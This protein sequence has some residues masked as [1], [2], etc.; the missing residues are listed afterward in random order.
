MPGGVIR[1][2]WLAPST[3]L[4]PSSAIATLVQPADATASTTSSAGWPVAS[5]ARR[6]AAMSLVMPLAVSVCTANTA[7]I[8]CCGSSRRAWATSA[9]SIGQP[10]RQGVRTT[11]RPRASVCTAQLSLKWPVPGISTAAPGGSRFSTATSQAP[12]PL[13]A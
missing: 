1:P 5:M 12:W 4:A 13:V 9:A 11:R 2:F 3:T 7:T 10:G 8:W 6:S